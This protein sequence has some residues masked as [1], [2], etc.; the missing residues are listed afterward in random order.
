MSV[1]HR[2]IIFLLGMRWAIP[3]IVT[4]V[5]WAKGNAVFV[6]SGQDDHAGCMANLVVV[7]RVRG[8]VL[9]FVVWVP[10]GCGV[11]WGVSMPRPARP[12]GVRQGM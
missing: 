4:R 9:A 1:C 11:R 2:G 12:V 8:V 7:P 10:C 5:G 6:S 3:R